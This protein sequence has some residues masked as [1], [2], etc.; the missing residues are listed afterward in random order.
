MRDDL[1]VM[2]G[3]V[4]ACAVSIAFWALIVIVWCLL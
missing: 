1:G 2:R 3:I 4:H